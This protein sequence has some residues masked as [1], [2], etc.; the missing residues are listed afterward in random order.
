GSALKSIVAA[1]LGIGLIPIAAPEFYAG[2]PSAL[3]TVLDSGISA[4]CLAAVVLNLIFGDRIR[5]STADSAADSA[6]DSPAGNAA[7]ADAT[8]KA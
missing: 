6:A 3:R 8:E 1:A 7:P 4:G 5:R 2:F